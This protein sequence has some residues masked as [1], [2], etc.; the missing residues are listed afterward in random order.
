MNKDTDPIYCG[1]CGKRLHI[2]SSKT[3][4]RGFDRQ[5]GKKIVVR[6]II[7]SCPKYENPVDTECT[8]LHDW[9]VKE[10]VE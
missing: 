3:G 9:I 2:D 5:T 4:E 1:Y 7:F 10:V 6:F 8:N